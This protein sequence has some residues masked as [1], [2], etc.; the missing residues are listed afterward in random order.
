[1]L[2]PF[3]I[4]APVLLLFVVALLG[5]TG[6]AGLLGIDEVS[7]A[8]TTGIKI[9]TTAA[10]DS[11]K[12]D[13]ATLDTTGANLIVFAAALFDRNAVTLLPPVGRPA[14]APA[15]SRDI[16]W[17]P[18]S[19]LNGP[20]GAVIA[21]WY[22]NDLK[23]EQVG[24]N[25]TL[26][27]PNPGQF[28]AVAVLCASGATAEPEGAHNAKSVSGHALLPVGAAADQG[29][30]IVTAIADRTT[31]GGPS[32]RPDFTG[33]VQFVPY[34]SLKHMGVAMTSL[35]P[36]AAGTKTVASNWNYDTFDPAKENPGDRAAIIAVF[37]K[38]T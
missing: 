16:V 18:L 38:A 13:E 35:V 2:D 37:K 15:T 23:P 5:F 31:G 29:D 17:R 22:A 32:C 19:P 34:L 12:T 25:H 28:P 14:G 8:A 9:L 4:L 30:L 33:D 11:T 24:A 26:R 21:M 1:M 6:C 7:Y 3:I 10:G 36:T 27:C 20:D